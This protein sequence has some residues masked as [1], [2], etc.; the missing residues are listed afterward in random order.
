M[1]DKNVIELKIKIDNKDAVAAI[2]LTDEN[3]NELYKTFKYGSSTT[4]DLT[5]R[6]SQGFN[7]AREILQGLQEVYG[8]FQST[9]GAQLTAYQEQERASVQLATA[10]QSAGIYTDEAYESLIAYSTQLQQT[11]IYG[12][13]LTIQTMAQ[14]TAMGLNADQLKEAT[15]QAANLA[16][17][18]GT[19]LTGAVRVMGDLFA[20]DATMINRYIKG[21]DETIL[22]SGNLDKILKMLNERIGGQAEAVGNT[23]YGQIVKYSNALGDLQENAGQLISNGIGPMVKMLGDL[24][25]KFNSANPG[26]SGMIGLLVS[27][28]ASFVTL[29]VTGILPAVASIQLFGTTLTGLRL[30]LLKTGIGALVVGLGFALSELASAYDKVADASARAKASMDNFKSTIAE[31]AAGMKKEEIE[32]HIANAKSEQSRIQ[33]EINDLEKEQEN[34]K[35][36][37]VVKDR[38]GNEYVLK[39][40]NERTKQLSNRIEMKRKELTAYTETATAFSDVLANMD[41]QPVIPKIDPDNKK[42]DQI[43]ALEKDLMLRAVEG[44]DREFRELEIWYS[45][46]LDLAG[47]NSALRLKITEAFRTEELRIHNKYYSEFRQMEFEKALES[48]EKQKDYDVKVLQLLGQG[49]DAILNREIQFYTEKLNLQRLFGQEA[50]DTEQQVALRRME[51]AAMVQNQSKMDEGRKEELRQEIDSADQSFAARYEA[52]DKWKTQE[53]AKYG[54]DAEALTL[55][56]QVHAQRRQEI[57]DQ[58]AEHKMQ[59]VSQAVGMAANLFG[60]HTLAYKLL[61][62]SQATMDTYR[63]ATAAL[64]PPPIGAGPVFGPILAAITTA[65]GL[66]NVA[67]IM[68]TETPKMTGYA[69][70]GMALVGEVGPEIIAPAMDYAEGQAMLINA[71]INKIG[72]GGDSKITR[73]LDDLTDA[74]NSWPERVEF[75]QRRGDLYGVLQKET[76]FR[77]RNR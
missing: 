77:E 75:V 17:L 34:A 1:A 39:Y 4:D 13:E 27:L 5:R 54:Q 76:R 14:L 30:L 21:L 65:A 12:D 44:R 63:A 55:I 15:L 72:M 23:G 61:A 6:I 9:L 7:N 48:L 25:N 28:T 62:A 24:I 33:K 68:S 67:K 42:A 29:R 45:E 64:A 49:Q 51:V 26:L 37:R 56:D 53:K 60:Q 59:S 73:K 16:S 70:G 74:I 58:E 3:I 18:M 41:K 38:E 11:T 66:A 47:D 8:I 52:L 71:V 31:Q 46:Q 20:G 43:A 22:K 69:T 2:Q 50:I 35:D 36:K 19:D 10:M 57:A 40:E 32:W